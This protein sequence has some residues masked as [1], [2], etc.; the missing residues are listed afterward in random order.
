MAISDYQMGEIRRKAESN[1]PLDAPTPEKTAV[2]NQMQDFYKSEI[3]KKAQAGEALSRPNDWKNSLYAQ[4]G[5]NMSVEQYM[6]QAQSNSAN[7]LSSMEQ[8]LK[9]ASQAQMSSQQAQLGLARDQALAQLEANLQKAIAQGQMSVREAEQQFT[10]A[11]QTIDEQAYR[12][13][14]MTNLTAHD[15]GIQNSAQMIGL[16]QG[17]QARANSLTSQAM[18]TRDQQINSINSQLDQLKYDTGVNKSLANSQYAYGL[19]GAEADIMAKMY[20]QMGEMSFAEMQR[21]A[22]N[23]FSMQ[24]AQLAQK[25]AMQQMAQQQNY[26]QMN[27]QKEHEFSLEK[28]DVQQRYTLEQMAKSFG[29]DLAKLDKQQQL[30]LAQMAQSFGYDMALQSSSQNFQAGMQERQFGYDLQMLREKQSLDSASYEE[31]LQ[32]QL[33]YYTTLDTSNMTENDLRQFQQ[34][35]AEL[36]SQRQNALNLT[37]AIQNQKL[38]SLIEAYPKMPGASATA[39]E[40]TAYEKQVESLNAQIEKITGSKE[41]T[42]Q[43]DKGVANGSITKEEGNQLANSLRTLVKSMPTMSNLMKNAYSAAK[44]FVSP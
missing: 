13:A 5:G 22:G 24:Q 4:S 6:Q 44:N 9:N 21:L 37:N 3:A 36:Q 38:A 23:E 27:M 39:K 19:A 32:R 34:A 43:V 2:Y 17:D 35:D 15:R 8:W 1:I 29:Y 20:G 25:Y 10:S 33:R 7:S 18:T 26:N 42:Y 12:D 28:L 30:Q 40:W 16:M 11:K 14:E 31:E 41:F